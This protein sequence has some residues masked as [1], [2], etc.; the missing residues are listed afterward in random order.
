MGSE[1]TGAPI[2][3]PMADDLDRYWAAA[4]R[5]DTLIDPV[6]PGDR[7]LPAI[8]AR[9]A[10][11]LERARAFLAFL[12]DPQDRFPIVHV[13]G[14]SGKGSTGAAIAAVLS[15]AGFRTGLATS[16]F[17]QVATEKLQIGERLIAPGA[18]ASLVDDVLE[19]AGRWQRQAPRERSLGHGE[20]SGGT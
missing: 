20:T 6:G 10:A 14:T 7:S 12:G 2:A 8:W 16:P 17:L 13:T 15:H 1:G 3:V 18:F 9:A 19:A 5:L 4:A 11:K